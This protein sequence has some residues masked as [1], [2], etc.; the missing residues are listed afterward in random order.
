MIRGNTYAT[1]Q[2]TP[3]AYGVNLAAELT[4]TGVTVNIYRPGTVG[5]AMQAWIRE[6][7]PARIGAALSQRFRRSHAEGTLITPEQSAAALLTRL[8]GDDTGGT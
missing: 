8:S 7:D 2:A 1:T 5:T 6:Q 3:E 4:G